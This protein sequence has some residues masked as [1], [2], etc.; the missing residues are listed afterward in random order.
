MI[1]FIGLFDRARDYALQFTI[2]HT[3]KC[4]E[5]RLHCRCLVAASNGGRSPSSGFPNYR[6]PHPP[7]SHSNSLQ[8]VNLNSSL[9]HSLT[10]STDSNC[11]AYNILARTSQK[12]PFLCCCL[13]AVVQQRIYMPQYPHCSANTTRTVCDITGS[14]GNSLLKMSDTVYTELQ[15]VQGQK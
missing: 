9:T 11:P 14:T 4:P 8:R 6:R 12:T 7:V 10:N 3:H 5:S 13:R 15:I 1:R 2:W